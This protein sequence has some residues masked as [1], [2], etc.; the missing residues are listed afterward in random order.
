[1]DPPNERGA[2]DDSY[3]PELE[4]AGVK[5][6]FLDYGYVLPDDDPEGQLLFFSSGTQPAAK[7]KIGL[8][9]KNK[10]SAFAKKML[11]ELDKKQ[12]EAA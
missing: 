6:T 3:D 9:G 4:W 2:A 1:V 8:G 10:V 5:S 7:S 12:E 11:R